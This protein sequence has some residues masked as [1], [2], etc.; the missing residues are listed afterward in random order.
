[1]SGIKIETLYDWV[2]FFKEVTDHLVSI[3]ETPQRDES[4]KALAKD[5]FGEKASISTYEK[6]DPFSFVY[7]LAQ[8]NT[9]HQKLVMYPRVKEKCNIVSSL[10]TDWI[11]PTPTANSVALFHNGV[12]FASEVLW[13]IFLRVTQKR[14]LEDADYR[15]LLSIPGV[16]TRKI[17][18]TLFLMDPRSFLPIDDRGSVLFPDEKIEDKI[19]D[20]ERNGVIHYYQYLTHVESLFP[21]CAFYEIN[22]LC[23]VV[24]SGNLS[25]NNTYFQIGSNVEGETDKHQDHKQEFYEEN[26]VWVGSANT[27]GKGVRRYRVEDPVKGDVILSHFNKYGNGIGVVFENEYARH[28]SYDEDLGIRVIWINKDERVGALESSQ[29][30]GFSRADAIRAS[31]EGIYPESFDVLNI[32]RNWSSTMQKNRKEDITNLII[33]G[34]PGTGKTRLAKQLALYLQTEGSTLQDF[35]TDPSKK[36]KEFPL[37]Q[38]DVNLDEYQATVKLVQFHP[39]YSYEDFIR[40]IVTE[41]DD[42][43]RLHY[44]EKNKVLAKIAKAADENRNRNYILII[45]EINRAYL[46]AVFGELIYALEYRD[47]EVQSPYKDPDSDENA[48]T[49]VLPSNLYI[50]GTMNTADRSIGRID[51]AIRRRFVFHTLGSDMEVIKNAKARALFLTVK[52]LIH[53]HI[54]TDFNADDVMVGHSYFLQKGDRTMQQRLDWE[55]KPLLMEYL[56]DG[57]LV[58][59]GVKELIENLA[60]G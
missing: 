33:E 58:G 3:G 26:K 37:F 11:F 35:L 8:K 40:G 21:K 52:G 13:D 51:Y 5:C 38:D 23:D 50:L 53:K 7:F 19:N 59:T 56:K 30:I 25:V 17:T 1:M 2:P 10:P 43:G 29:S 15:T 60:D 36:M 28:G 39:G 6:V 57:I 32:L 49:I 42:Q 20:I 55:I 4:L 31:F 34:P 47:E 12:H 46:S 14:E 41:I 9:T 24:H 45:D 54:S 48:S 44:R 22:L 16:R 27:G 18:Q